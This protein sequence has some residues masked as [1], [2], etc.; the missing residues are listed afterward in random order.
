MNTMA[1]LLRSSLHL[2]SDTR[3]VAVARLAL[4][5]H[6]LTATLEGSLVSGR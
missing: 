2:T 5:I 3:E 1:W 6:T 4:V